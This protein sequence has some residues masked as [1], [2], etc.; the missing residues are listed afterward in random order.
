MNAERLLKIVIMDLT[1]DNLKLEQELERI[2]NSDQDI[3]SKTHTIKSILSK[4]VS[5]DASIIKFSGMMNNN[6]EVKTKK[7]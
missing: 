7:K 5:I 2:I 4:M 6:N 3:E 1:T